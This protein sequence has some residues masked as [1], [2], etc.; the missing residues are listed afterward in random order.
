MQSSSSNVNQSQAMPINVKVNQCQMSINVKQ[1]QSW[2]IMVPI[3]G[4]SWPINGQSMTS[5]VN[6]GKAMSI[7][8]QV[9]V[10]QDEAMPINVK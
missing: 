5:N 6:Q 3:N 1:C 2:S 9:N 4:Q 8:V 7:K 10:N